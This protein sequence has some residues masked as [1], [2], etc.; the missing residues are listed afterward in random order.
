[1]RESLKKESIIRLD[2]MKNKYCGHGKSKM[3]SMHTRELYRLNVRSQEN[4]T[5]PKPIRVLKIMK[6]LD[7]ECKKI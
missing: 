1:M 7:C 5:I 2:V 6:K 3:D 4:S